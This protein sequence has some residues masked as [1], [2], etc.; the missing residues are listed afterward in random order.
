M[1]GEEVV[2]VGG[3]RTPIGRAGKGSLV[4]V[5]PDDMSALVM[6]ALMERT[7]V[8][9]ALVEDVKWGC[10]FP[11]AEQ[12][13]NFARNSIILAGFPYSVP[14][15][16]LNRYCSSSLEAVNSAAQAIACGCAEVVMAGG[17]E[18]MS[19]IPMGGLQAQKMLNA[20]MFERTRDEPQAL[21]MSQTG[22]Y[23]AEAYGFT[24]E[25]MDR[26]AKESQDRAVAAQDAG[27]FE[28]QI[29]PVPYAA[30]DKAERLLEADECPRR[31][32]SL[33]KM[34]TLP[35]IVAPITEGHQEA[36]I[37]AGN[38]C[39]LNDGAA[40]V[41]VMSRSKARDLGITPF[42]KI[43]GQAVAGVP[44]YEMGIGPV[45]A[46]RTCLERAGLTLEDLD[47]IELNEA[48]AVQCLDF[49][50]ELGIAHSKLNVN[51]GAIA[52]GHPFGMTGARLVIMLMYEMRRR[53][54][55]YG[56]ASLCVGGGMGGST[57]GER[58]ADWK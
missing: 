24:R 15:V 54:S 20:K 17:A 58:E 21:L 5:R 29:V 31:G 39:P 3:V 52:L 16:T 1:K 18:S 44:P 28:D 51:G 36:Y 9:P 38:S 53:D 6:K 37:T 30:Q 42:V 33:E 13:G 12:G 23:I 7:G 14:G 27:V 32:V 8:D 22:Q 57:A 25:E 56:L 45:P 35:V 43:A 19:M 11:E 40:A 26:Y 4:E 2:V 10:G 50:R 41:L 49:M 48:F 47:L 34:A 55:R 46:T